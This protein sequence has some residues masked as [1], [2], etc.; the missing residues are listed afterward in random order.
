MK[1]LFEMVYTP[2]RL[3]SLVFR[4]AFDVMIYPDFS[5][6]LGIVVKLIAMITRRPPY[7]ARV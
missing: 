6:S 7:T 4:S 3:E 5:N 2:H 1:N